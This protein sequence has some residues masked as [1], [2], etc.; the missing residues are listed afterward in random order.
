MMHSIRATAIVAAAVAGVVSLQAVAAQQPAATGGCISL[1]GSS[2]CPSFQ[3]AFI[4]PTSLADDWSFFNN[5][6]DVASFDAR[7]AAY[8]VSDRGY[9]A[10]QIANGL[11]CRTEAAHNVTLQWQQTIFCS[12]FA[13]QSFDAGCNGAG[14]EGQDPAPRPAPVCEETCV[15]FVAS[16]HSV[17][18]FDSYCPN[19]GALTAAQNTTRYDTLRT[20]FRTC[21]DRSLDATRNNATCVLGINN[22]GSC[23]F[24]SSVDQLCA[25]CDPRYNDQLPSC[26]FDART[27]L[28]TDNVLSDGQLAGAIVGCIVGALLLGALLALL[29]LR[30][31]RKDRKD[32]EANATGAGAV[33]GNAANGSHVERPWMQSE[34]GMVKSP[35]LGGAKDGKFGAGGAAGAALGAGA[36]GAGAAAAGAAAGK[37]RD[38]VDDRPI[39]AMSGETGTDGR[40]TTIPAVKDQYSSHDICTGETVVAIYPYNA[41]L[42][43]EISLQPDDVITVQ[44]LYD[45]GWALGRTEA[46]TEGAF[47]LR[48]YD[49]GWALG[50]TEAGTEG[51]FPLVC[52]TSTKG[53]TTS[54]GSGEGLGSSTGGVTSG[55][56][57]NV[58]SSVDGAVTADE[59]FTSDATGLQQRR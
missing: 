47:P 20:N 41:T 14:S 38:S 43:D 52:V 37:G 57:G 2:A 23:G 40:G 11:Q 6:T 12:R 21:T 32:T 33:Y 10:D 46:G 19:D 26:C 1:K 27:D 44:R 22:E 5:V 3:E 34:D 9:Y 24:A 54:G 30:C 18:D 42:N 15:Q 31:C 50:R 8:L 25:H 56:D 39:S 45:D 55:N 29:L 17:L 59:G 51:A 16:E 49:D 58:T 53:G 13:Q 28:S 35:E 7:F 36:L 4:N 48:L